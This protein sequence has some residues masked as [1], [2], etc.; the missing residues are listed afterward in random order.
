MTWLRQVRSGI[1]KLA[2]VLRAFGRQQ[3][4]PSFCLPIVFCHAHTKENGRR[5][6]LPLLSP[7]ENVYAALVNSAI[8]IP[9][10]PAVAVPAPVVIVISA[11]VIAVHPA[12]VV[13]VKIAPIIPVTIAVIP[14]VSV[15]ISVI[16]AVP[17]VI[18]VTISHV[19]R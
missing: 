6:G 12:I 16:V 10:H 2:F 5:F 4:R 1:N 19:L 14:P 3:C 8:A 15:A 18:A 9:I 13:A 7:P 17:I 11:I